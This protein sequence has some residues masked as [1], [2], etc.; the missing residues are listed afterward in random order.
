MFVAQAKEM[1]LCAKLRLI[2]MLFSLAMGILFG[3]Y[4]WHN[5]QLILY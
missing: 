5:I 1:I 4:N 3:R 2:N